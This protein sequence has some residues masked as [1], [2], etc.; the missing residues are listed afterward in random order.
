MLQ[1]QLAS[2]W[3]LPSNVSRLAKTVEREPIQD[4]FREMHAAIIA[5]KYIQ[6]RNEHFH[7][8]HLK[9]Y[10]AYKDEFSKNR[11]CYLKA[12]IHYESQS[13]EPISR[14]SNAVER[15]NEIA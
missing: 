13:Y 10:G 1:C 11:T 6:P 8:G 5:E 9:M 3:L 4:I 2:D 12:S 15:T 7:P 14:Y